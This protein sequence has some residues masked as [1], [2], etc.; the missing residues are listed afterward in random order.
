MIFVVLRNIHFPI[1]VHIYIYINRVPLFPFHMEDIHIHI[2][3]YYITYHLV[4]TFTVHHGKIHHAIKNGVYMC[5]RSIS[6]G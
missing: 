3:S 2:I 5:L 4:M 6:M 1:Y